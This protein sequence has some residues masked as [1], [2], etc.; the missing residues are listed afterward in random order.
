MET[1]VLSRTER[2]LYDGSDPWRLREHAQGLIKEARKITNK[3]D[4]A[5]ESEARELEQQHAELIDKIDTLQSRA[6]EIERE[7]DIGSTSLGNNPNPVKPGEVNLRALSPRDSF[8]HTVEGERVQ[9]GLGAYFRA[10][11][12]GARDDNERRALESG[13]GGSGGFTMPAVLAGRLIDQLRARSIAVRLGATTVPLE[14]GE[15]HIARVASDPAPAWRAELGAVAESDPTFSRIE[16][17]PKSLA[18]IVRISRELLADSINLEAQLPQIIAASMAVEWDRAALFGSGS[19]S[20][21]LGLAG[22][23][24]QEITHDAA[25]TGY[26]PLVNAQT[27]VATANAQATGFAMHPRDAGTLNGLM[28][29]D[30]QPLQ[31][32]R[33]IADL[34]MLT[35]TSVPTDGGT[36]TNESTILTGDWRHLLLG[37]REEVNVRVLSERYADTGEVG[38]I[39]HFRGDT[40]VEHT[41]AFAKITG[42]TP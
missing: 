29:S 12:I 24:I 16:L 2:K 6:H 38:M 5:S 30:S 3:I 35:S 20:E 7:S 36:G 31:V 32:P 23:S 4:K 10:L 34:P 37:V 22:H 42:I 17:T 18:V 19:S 33:S 15:N 1:S 9:C 39:V 40:A 27:L 41:G 14:S 25:L 13:T 8:E 11:T 26:V 28:A 21:P